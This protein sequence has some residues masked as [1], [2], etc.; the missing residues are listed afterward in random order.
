MSLRKAKNMNEHIFRMNEKIC[1]MLGV[2]PLHRLKSKENLFWNTVETNGR[3]YTFEYVQKENIL[4]FKI[5]EWQTKKLRF[6]LELGSLRNPMSLNQIMKIRE[7][8]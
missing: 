4:E 5:I 6:D 3:Q 8:L 1:T 2:I 7:T